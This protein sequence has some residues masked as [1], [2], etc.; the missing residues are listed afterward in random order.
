[1][2][3]ASFAQAQV[4]KVKVGLLMINADAGVFVAQERVTSAT[5]GWQL[6]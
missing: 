3:T 5:R 1:L 2:F 6:R 4:E